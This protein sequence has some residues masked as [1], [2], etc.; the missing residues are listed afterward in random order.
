MDQKIKVNQ[1]YLVSSY[2]KY[3]D[4]IFLSDDQNYLDNE[5]RQ[6]CVFILKEK[7]VA[8]LERYTLYRYDVFSLNHQKKLRLEYVGLDQK[9]FDTVFQNIL[10]VNFEERD[11]LSH[12]F[13]L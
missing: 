1:V 13:L 9:T 12:E 7:R 6:F 10:S 4:K 11:R 2:E 3:K 8:R 5:S